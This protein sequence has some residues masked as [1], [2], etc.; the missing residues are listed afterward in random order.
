MLMRISFEDSLREDA[1]AKEPCPLPW[2]MKWWWGNCLTG[3]N[4]KLDQRRGTLG[5]CLLSTP[6]SRSSW[7]EEK[8]LGPAMDWRTTISGP[9]CLNPPPRET[10]SGSAGVH[11]MWKHQHGGKSSKKFLARVTS[12]NLPGGACIIPNTKSKIT[13]LQSR[14][15]LLCTASTPVPGQGS[16]PATPGQEICSQDYQMIQPQKTLVYAKALQH[17]VEKAQ[18]PIP[19]KSHWLAESVLEL[20]CE[21]EPLMTFTDEE[22]LEDLMQSNWMRITPSKLKEPA[23]SG[24]KIHSCSHSRSH[25]TNSRGLFLATCSIGWLTPTATAQVA[26]WSATPTQKEELQQEDTTSQWQTPPPG[27]VEIAWSL[28][29]D[30]PPRKVCNIP[31]DMAEEQDPIQ[32]VGS[33]MFSAWLF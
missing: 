24:S 6:K 1:E 27:F 12:K 11:T 25:R 3:P 14:E 8:C 33:T 32:M 15:W 18:P 31:P 20:W 29:G 9:Q 13:C 19:G 2:G 23:L 16:V 22:V 5:A 10:T 30:N 26:S 7:Q 28:C 4:L 17:W 21:M